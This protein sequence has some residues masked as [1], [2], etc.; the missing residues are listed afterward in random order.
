M[1]CDGTRTLKLLL[2]SA[3]SEL[4]HS[5]SLC[6]ILRSQ[7]SHWLLPPPHHLLS[8][9]C[10]SDSGPRLPALVRVRCRWRCAAVAAS[11]PPC[12]SDPAAC[13][14]SAR[15][16]GDR[17]RHPDAAEEE[18]GLNERR[19]FCGRDLSPLLTLSFSLSD[20]IL[21]SLTLTPPTPFL[22]SASCRRS[23][24]PM[25]T[26]GNKRS[27]SSQVSSC[28]SSTGTQDRRE[29]SL[30]VCEWMA[31]SV[32]GRVYPVCTCAETFGPPSGIPEACVA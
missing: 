9:Q 24:F 2:P 7:L 20:S 23:R 6:V 26:E 25:R 30:C 17:R 8:P 13:R 31:P 12:G 15:C 21:V 11:S 27:S 19:L 16:G 28:S 22:S 32:C 14:S 29:S 3:D 1:Q 5:H 18:Q 4:G 10:P